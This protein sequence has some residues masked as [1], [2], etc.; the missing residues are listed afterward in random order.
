M[1]KKSNQQEKLEKIVYISWEGPDTRWESLPRQRPYGCSLH[2]TM[3]DY[4]I[5][6]RERV[7]K[8]DCVHDE[9]AQRTGKPRMGR[10][11][12]SSRIVQVRAKGTL[13]SNIK[14]HAT[15]HGLRLW[16]DEETQAVE[17]K[18]LVYGKERS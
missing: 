13:Y 14:A 1:N 15:A 2:L 7:R 6:E 9:Y 10:P 11:A 16:Q 4:T 8:S 18:E 17:M 3:E 5:Y 12:G